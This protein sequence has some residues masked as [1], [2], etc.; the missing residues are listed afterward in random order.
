[1]WTVGRW[2][3]EILKAKIFPNNLIFARPVDR[4]VVTMKKS[5]HILI[6]FIYLYIHMYIYIYIYI[7]MY[8]C[9]CVCV[10]VCLSQVAQ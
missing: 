8:V 10:F 3:F 1:M 9:V 4:S 2:W 6:L 5:W 7:Y